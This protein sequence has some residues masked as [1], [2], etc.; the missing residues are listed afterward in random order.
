MQLMNAYFSATRRQQG[1]DDCISIETNPKLH[2]SLLELPSHPV[3]REND[4]FAHARTHTH[5][6]T[7]WDWLWLMHT[8]I[9]SPGWLLPCELCNEDKLWWD[10]KEQMLWKWKRSGRCPGS[11]KQEKTVQ[12]LTCYTPP[13]KSRKDTEAPATWEP[14]KYHREEKSVTLEINSE[15]KKHFLKENFGLAFFSI[16]NTFT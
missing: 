13:A 6:H 12:E 9:C 5:A 7:H 4:S 3:W 1:K 14:A 2:P 11:H 8:C 10:W 16:Q 15:K